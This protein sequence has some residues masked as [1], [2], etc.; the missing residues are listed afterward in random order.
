MSGS[1]FQRIGVEIRIESSD[2]D[3][4][5]IV[6]GVSRAVNVVSSSSVFG[7]VAM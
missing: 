1:G 6:L 5:C 7:D 3:G 4:F 2:K